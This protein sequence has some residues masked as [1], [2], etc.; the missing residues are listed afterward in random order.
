MQAVEQGSP[1]F[2]A[3]LSPLD[4]ITHINGEPVQGLQHARVVA[5]ISRGGSRLSLRSV[6]M[7]KTS[8]RTCARRRSNAEPKLAKP[9]AAN[10]KRHQRHRSGDGKRRPSLFR[11]LSQRR[12]AADQHQQHH[13]LAS[14]VLTP[15]RSFHQTLSRSFST[16]DS[17]APHTAA[18]LHAAAGAMTSPRSPP[19]GRV[20]SSGS[21]SA[22][23]TANSSNNSSP[24][25]S[26]PNSPAAA[27]SSFSSRPSTLHGL[28]HKHKMKQATSS[29]NRRKSVHNIPLSPLARTPSPSPLATSPTRSPS[30]LTVVHG[31]GQV[32]HPPGISNMTQTYNPA[33]Q[34]TSPSPNSSSLSGGAGGGVR[35]VYTR[36]RSFAEPGSPLLRRALSPDRLHPSSA[37]KSKSLQ[38]H[39]SLQERKHRPYDGAGS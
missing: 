17:V 6:P 19:L 37:E 22:N 15:S 8:I 28:K 11:K 4:L 27:A 13:H 36:P 35:R 29:T 25:S 3:G 24:S 21:D 20:W 16:G 34:Q 38:R 14:P 10:K 23:S 1:A 12:A 26:L 32:L 31:H 33:H 9:R 18:S 39:A 5:L 7:D 30:P 2:E